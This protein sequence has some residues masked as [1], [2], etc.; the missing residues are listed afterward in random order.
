M[1]IRKTAK[2]RKVMLIGVAYK[3]NVADV[4]ES[5]AFAI[6]ELL[7]AQQADICFHDPFVDKIPPLRE[8][9]AFVGM[10]STALTAENLTAQDAVI[11]VT[12]HSD[13]DYGF[14]AA[15]SSLVIDTRNAA[16][17]ADSAHAGKIV[18]A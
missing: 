3:K 15:H 2:R 5:P 18:K 4:R 1:K 9:P 14:V 17:S 16:K 8:H 12:D 11:I 10:A 6:M 13:I 7:K